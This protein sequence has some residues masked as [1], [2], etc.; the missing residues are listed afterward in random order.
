MSDGMFKESDVLDHDA[1][2]AAFRSRLIRIKCMLGMLRQGCRSGRGT[3]PSAYKSWVGPRA[4]EPGF[5]KMVALARTT[6]VSLD[7][8]ATGAPKTNIDIACDQGSAR[9]R[10]LIRTGALPVP[11]DPEAPTE[12]AE[13]TSPALACGF[14][15]PCRAALPLGA[16]LLLA[17]GLALSILAIVIA[18]L[19]RAS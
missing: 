12:V 8:L 11:I 9:A 17:S 10:W 15:T 18:L 5:L 7:Y 2:S 4:S 6:G 16:T 1:A 13:E 14:S 3:T 19:G